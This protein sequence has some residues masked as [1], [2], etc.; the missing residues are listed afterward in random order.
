MIQPLMANVQA[1]KP[2]CP[3]CRIIFATQ[4]DVD[5]HLRLKSPCK[6]VEGGGVEGF[7][8]A[9]KRQLHSKKRARAKPEEDKWRDIYQILF[10]S[11]KDTPDPFYDPCFD[12]AARGL[13]TTQAGHCL[14]VERIF[15]DGVLSEIED[16][17]C[18]ELEEAVEAHLSGRKRR[19][20]MEVFRAFAV[21]V[22]RQGTAAGRP[23]AEI[24]ENGQ[25][26]NTRKGLLSNSALDSFGSGVS[27]T[28]S[29]A[30]PA[31]V[32]D[33]ED[34]HQSIRLPETTAQVAMKAQQ[35]TGNENFPWRTAFNFGEGLNLTAWP[36]GN[37]AVV[38]GGY[39]LAGLDIFASC[40]QLW[41]QV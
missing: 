15:A 29:I 7:D 17:T 5:D 11:C 16:E 1:V 23:V 8:A 21:K 24:R 22:L 12:G 38:E 34:D 30:R 20:A 26:Q 6:V 19:K 28:V 31:I 39:D 41:N 32:H 13:S 10:P 27:P 3:R 37:E 25:G 33:A 9:Q 2:N 36:D 35:D 14:D 40:A 18:V 4:E